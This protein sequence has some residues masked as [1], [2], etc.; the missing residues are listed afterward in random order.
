[1]T[2]FHNSVS[3]TLSTV[4]TEYIMVTLF[5]DTIE[6]NTIFVQTSPS[7]YIDINLETM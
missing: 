2:N 3:K 1:M 7:L 6:L 4:I 5:Q